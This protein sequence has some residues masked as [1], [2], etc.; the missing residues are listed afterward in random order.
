MTM[1]WS[2]DLFPVLASCLD[3]HLV[4]PLLKF[5]EENAGTTDE[6]RE[7]QVALLHILVKT[8]MIDYALEVW[9][10]CEKVQPL[11]E[12]EQRDLG[13]QKAL[14]E[15]RDSVLLALKT[16]HVEVRPLLQ[17]A[18]R[19]AK[20]IANSATTLGS[21]SDDHHA[22]QVDSRVSSAGT[23]PTSPTE[24]DT[25]SSLDSNG[26]EEMITFS[27]PV[28]QMLRQQR[29]EFSDDLFDALYEYARFQFDCGNYAESRELLRLYRALARNLDW[30]RD[31]A[32]SWGA[33]AVEILESR[34]DAALEELQKLRE[35]ISSLSGSSTPALNPLQQLQQ[36]T[37][38][39]HW[40]L[41]IF[42]QSS[43]AQ[44]TLIDMVFP[45]NSSSQGTGAINAVTPSVASAERYLT[46]IETNAAHLYRYVIAALVMSTRRQKRNLLRE[47]VRFIELDG[48]KIVDDPI[49]GFIQSL[50]GNLDFES[51]ERKLCECEPA[52]RDDL[53]LRGSVDVFLENARQLILE[54]YCR[55]HDCV[56]L[57]ECADRLHMDRACAERWIA[58]FVRNAHLEAKID[59]RQNQILMTYQPLSVYEHIIDMTRSLTYRTTSLGYA[60]DR[61]THPSGGAGRSRGHGRQGRGHAGTALGAT[62]GGSSGSRHSQRDGRR[63]EA[64][65]GTYAATGTVGGV[66]MHHAAREVSATTLEG[67]LSGAR[68]H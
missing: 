40:G 46:V 50:I 17:A 52:L 58:S 60:L 9:Q 41:F 15:R 67:S 36:R 29:A 48:Y 35:L 33:L 43:A 19:A 25:E 13:G 42:F 45:S 57:Y 7:A 61:D 22:D 64:A 30:E 27:E 54:T 34:W 2:H 51:A 20:Q 66:T 28:I 6:R 39:L 21:Q 63:G 59:D 24:T 44:H 49:V 8:N 65:T 18:A 10:E 38:L 37:W 31:L 32:F 11:S 4:I 12:V 68:V 23:Q 62:A 53:F 16:L 55:I 47:L 14:A 3:R 1:I 26:T 5:L 56:D